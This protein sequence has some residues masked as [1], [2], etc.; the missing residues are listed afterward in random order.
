M[1][2]CGS[3]TT[4]LL[5]KIMNVEDVFLGAASFVIRID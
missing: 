4:S 1:K 2:Q 5:K 3:H